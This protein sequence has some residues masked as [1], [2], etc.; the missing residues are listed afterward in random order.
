MKVYL[1]YNPKTKKG[2][3]CGTIKYQ[4]GHGVYAVNC[5]GKSGRKVFVT[6]DTNYLQLAEVQVFG[7]GNNLAI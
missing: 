1:D 6:H 2:T 4:K 3:L 7:K 5:G